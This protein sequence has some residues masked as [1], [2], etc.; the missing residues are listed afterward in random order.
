LTDALQRLVEQ[1]ENDLSLVEPDQ[2]RRRLEALDR[3]D[4]YL[5]CSNAHAA[6][7]AAGIEP[8]LQRR[9]KAICA[10]LE[11]TNGALYESIRGEIQQAC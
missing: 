3:I 4:A 1:F 7:A 5:P 9:A 10:R 6:F 2:L 8:E 11:A